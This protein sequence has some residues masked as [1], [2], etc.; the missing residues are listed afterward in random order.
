MEPTNLQTAHYDYTISATGYVTRAGK[1]VI[2][3][4]E[5]DIE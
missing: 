4:D 5:Q 1:V 3:D 2:Y